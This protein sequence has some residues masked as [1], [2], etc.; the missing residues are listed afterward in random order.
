MLRL[1]PCAPVSYYLKAAV[2]QEGM[3]VMGVPLY[4][5]VCPAPLVLVQTVVP[6]A[7][8]RSHALSRTVCVDLNFALHRGV[9]VTH[10][11]PISCPEMRA[12]SYRKGG[13]W[14]SYRQGRERCV[15]QARKGCITQAGKVGVSRVCPARQPVVA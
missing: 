3:R 5:S 8:K 10:I 4:G 2:R 7:R 1:T 12:I 13:R 9:H 6:V 11:A 14:V 15:L